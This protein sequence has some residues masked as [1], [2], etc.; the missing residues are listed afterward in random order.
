MVLR[1]QLDK[2]LRPLSGIYKSLLMPSSRS[3][4]DALVYIMEEWENGL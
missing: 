1:Q 4:G 3:T 2:L